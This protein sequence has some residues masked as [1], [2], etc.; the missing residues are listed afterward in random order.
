M[1]A[2]IGP[3]LLMVVGVALLGFSLEAS[4]KKARFSADKTHAEFIAACADAKGKVA[5]NGK[6]WECIK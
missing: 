2:F 3:I 5:F 6:H 4:W 1:K